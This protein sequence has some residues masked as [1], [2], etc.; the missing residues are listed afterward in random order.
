MHIFN[1]TGMEIYSFGDDP[2]LGGIVGGG[3][4]R[5]RRLRP[6]HLLGEAAPSV[7]VANFR[8]EFKARIEPKGLP[9]DV[10]QPYRPNA[11]GWAQGTIYLADLAGMRVVV[12]DMDGRFVA[13]HDLAKL[14]DVAEKRADN[15]IKG[16][17]VA[18]DGDILFTVQP[19][20][21]AFVL[22]SRDGTL[23][24]FGVEEAP[25]ASSTSSPASPRDERGYYYVADILKSA[26]LVFD[27][28]FRWVKEFGYRGAKPGQPRGP[29]GRRGG[30]RKGLRLPVREAR[31]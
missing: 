22:C 24:S 3:A 27:K 8:G 20:F 25:P 18:P 21:R 12:L 14:C 5:G 17:R 26:V 19:L 28:N 29:G 15:G 10:P 30:R 13:Y 11:I 1:P 6:P 4:H 23:L 7:V 9:A 2:Q 16:F 31:A